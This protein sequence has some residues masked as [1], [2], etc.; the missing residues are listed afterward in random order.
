MPKVCLICAF[1][2]FFPCFG[3]KTVPFLERESCLRHGITLVYNS[4]I[5]QALKMLMIFNSWIYSWGYREHS[6]LVGWSSGVNFH[7]MQMSLLMRR[8]FISME[9][10]FGH[11]LV[12][13][14]YMLRHV[15]VTRIFWVKPVSP[16]KPCQ[17]LLPFE[18]DKLFENGK[19]TRPYKDIQNGHI[20]IFQ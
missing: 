1:A 12:L 7:C 14:H 6:R 5:R 15:H 17:T 16:E 9:H 4:S 19:I 3:T 11:V 13:A 8:R 2:C 20:W 10:H 18:N